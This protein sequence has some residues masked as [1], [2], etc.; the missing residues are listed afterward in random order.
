MWLALALMNSAKPPSTVQPVTCCF[1]H[2][3]SRPSKQNSHSPHVQ[4]NHGTAT[5]SPAA[6]PA[7]PS[8]TEA[9]VPVTSCPSVRG[10]FVIGLSRSHSPIA[11]CKSEWQTP[12]AATLINTSPA[13]GDGVVI[14]SILKRFSE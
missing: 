14:S 11:K 8:P 3:V 9:I 12:Q 4:C 5:R 7:T 10:N 13:P 2:S 1:E 6:N